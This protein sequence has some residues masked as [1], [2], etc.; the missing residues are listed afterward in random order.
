[1]P[2]ER[3]AGFWTY[4]ENAFNDIGE[5]L[6]YFAPANRAEPPYLKQIRVTAII[7]VARDGTLAGIELIDGMPPPPKTKTE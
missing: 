4:D 5:H 2:L 7:D 3:R 1:M 6:Y